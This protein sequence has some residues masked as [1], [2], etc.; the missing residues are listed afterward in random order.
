MRVLTVSDKVVP[1]LYDRHLK[2]VVG[3]VDL[4]ISCGDV[5]PYYLDFLS[6]TLNV[7]LFFV[8]GNHTFGAHQQWPGKR[9][10]PSGANLHRR[11][12]Q[13]QGLL[14]AGLEGSRRYRPR[15]P[16]QYTEGEMLRNCLT[17]VPALLRNRLVYGRFLDV[18][19]THAP[20]RHIHDGEDVAHRGFSCF[21]WFMRVFRPRYLIHGHMHVYRHDIPTV[22]RFAETTVI[23]TYPYRVLTLQPASTC[24]PLSR[25]SERAHRIWDHINVRWQSFISEKNEE[26]VDV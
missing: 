2:Q 19:I 21:R 23:N 8:Y 26:M 9:S 12:V 14:L 10:L 20:P 24:S 3:S 7:P 25:I 11:V 1:Y 18:L 13:Y 5:P 16:H 15:A 4:L 17:L 6:T 22:T